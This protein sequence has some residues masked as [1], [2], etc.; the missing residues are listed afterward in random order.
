MKEELISDIHVTDMTRNGQCSNCGECCT[1]FIPMSRS[2]VN[3]IKKYLKSH[4][5]I[6]EQRHAL[7]KYDITCPFR[8]HDQK[9][10]LIYE[11]RPEVCRRFLC[12]KD[13]NSLLRDKYE[14]HRKNE[15][16]Q[17]RTVFFKSNEYMRMYQEIFSE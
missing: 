2:E 13:Q 7:A 12:N 14:M 4:P 10:C 6:K 8:S 11:V 5:E 3:R 1:D 17:M 15:V 16:V 9:K